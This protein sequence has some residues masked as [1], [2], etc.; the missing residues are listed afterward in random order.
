MSSETTAEIIGL[1]I[2]FW[3][4]LDTS[5]NIYK[6]KYWMSMR[7]INCYHPRLT[8]V[9]WNSWFWCYYGQLIYF[10]RKVIAMTKWTYVIDR[11]KYGV[12][13]KYSPLICFFAFNI[14]LFSQ[15]RFISLLTS[16]VLSFSSYLQFQGNGSTQIDSYSGRNY[17]Y[18]SRKWRSDIFS[19]FI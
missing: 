18:P 12:G 1:D 10:Y 7:I 5:G 13:K 3:H 15:P 2:L 16:S 4:R 6:L 19:S 8:Y 17:S 14:L 11:A 9:S